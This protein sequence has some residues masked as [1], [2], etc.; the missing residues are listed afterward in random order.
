MD[1]QDKVD[2]IVTGIEA[3][4]KHF[5]RSPRQVRRW[6]RD[7]APRLSQN[8]FDLLQIQAWLDQRQGVR[9]PA[10]PGYIDPRQRS[11][12]DA[13]PVSTKDQDEARYAK[14][15]ADLKEM[16]AK[17]R[18]GELVELKEIEQLF[19]ARILACKQGLLTLQ[20]S[21][22]PKLIHCRDEREME[23]IIAGAVREL[24]LA[25]SRPLP[26]SLGGV[27]VDLDDDW[28]DGE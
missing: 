9:Q 18:L 13:A 1:V 17:K 8:R 7:G 3:V 26:E 4:A 15:R 27:A 14:A 5:G 6:L 2:S 24:L 23:I 21:L 20:R 12:G 22:P 11:L 19:V 10:G 25:F 16:E 28:E